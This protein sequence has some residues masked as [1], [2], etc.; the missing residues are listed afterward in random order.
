MPKCLGVAG[1]VVCAVLASACGGRD[2]DVNPDSRDPHMHASSDDALRQV[3][4]RDV[5]AATFGVTTHE[6]GSALERHLAG[7]PAA[8]PMLAKWARMPSGG[9][10]LDRP[11]LAATALYAFIGPGSKSRCGEVTVVFG[12]GQ[13]SLRARL[14]VPAT[15]PQC[16]GILRDNHVT[17]NEA[18]SLLKA[19]IADVRVPIAAN[20]PV[21][22]AN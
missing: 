14:P 18:L 8:A 7:H 5:V 19:A 16:R 12:D 2:V 15:T 20:L 13:T 1:L 22:A 3:P 6:A 11:P 17:G 9:L 21:I 4:F 10:D